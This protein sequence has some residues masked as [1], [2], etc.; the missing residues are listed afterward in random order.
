MAS[1]TP[2]TAVPPTTRP[3]DTGSPSALQEIQ[4]AALEAVPNAIIIAD[5]RGCIVWVNRAFSEAT[6]YERDEVIGRTPGSLLRSGV[7][8]AGFYATLWRTVLSGGVWQGIVCNRRRDGS[9][10]NE[11][12]TVAPIRGADGRIGYFVAVKT[13][14]A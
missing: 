8:D 14:L 10:H 1:P 7:H 3:S 9:L 4:A 13:D 11:S 5:R 2:A 12:M 6:G